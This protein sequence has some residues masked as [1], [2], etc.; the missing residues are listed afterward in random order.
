MNNKG[1][2]CVQKISLLMANPG[3]L[4]KPIAPLLRQSRRRE[5]FKDKTTAMMES[6]FCLWRG[7]KM[8]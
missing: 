4:T 6:N 3:R 8:S 2:T 5:Y 7:W 1:I